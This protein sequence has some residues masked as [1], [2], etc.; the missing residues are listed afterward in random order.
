MSTLV[1]ATAAD[2]CTGLTVTNQVSTGCLVL[3]PTITPP[4]LV[5]SRVSGDQFAFAFDTEPSRTY[6]VQYTDEL[7]PT[8]WQTLSVFIGAGGT[9]TITDSKS[10]PHRFY[11]VMVQ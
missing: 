6:T 4:V 8:N 5:N 7:V 3:C 2:F 11:R 1:T 9:V 10:N